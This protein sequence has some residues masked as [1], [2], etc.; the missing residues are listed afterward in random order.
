MK[1]NSTCFDIRDTHN[2][3]RAPLLRFVVDLLHGML[4]DNVCDESA[5]SWIKI[6]EA[7][8]SNF[9]TSI[10]KFSTGETWVLTISTL[11]LNFLRNV[12]FKACSHCV[13]HRTMRRTAPDGTVKFC[14]FRRHF[15]SIR[16][17]FTDRLKFKGGGHSGRLLSCF[18]RPSDRL[19]THLSV[20][21]IKYYMD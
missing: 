14:I 10:C 8:S 4:L 16:R 2:E 7:A 5:A 12:T 19:Q 3:A 21:G 15:F 18:R 17:K 1:P 20:S 13:R 6:L 9:P 11:P